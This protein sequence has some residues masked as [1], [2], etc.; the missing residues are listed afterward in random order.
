[1][2]TP[3]KLIQFAR[4]RFNRDAAPYWYFTKAKAL[5][6]SSIPEI[7]KYHQELKSIVIDKGRSWDGDAQEE[8]AQ[9]VA[10]RPATSAWARELKV[11]F[12]VLG[13][14]WVEDNRQVMFTDMGRRLL[15]TDD[16][17]RLLSHQIRKFQISNPSLSGSTG[18]RLLPHYA[19]L[20]TLI[21]LRDSHITK[22]EFILFV[23]HLTDTDNDLE[24]ICELIE[25][26]RKLSSADQT[27]FLESLSVNKRKILGRIWSYMANFLSFP[28]YLTYL[29]ARISIANIEEARS[30]LKWYEAGHAEYIEFATNKD[31][32]SYYGGESM[33]LTTL[34]AIH[35]YRSRGDVD[36]AVRTFKRAVAAGQVS[37]GESEQDFRCRIQGE[38]MLENW[39]VKHLNRLK[40]GLTFQ[41]SQYETE[42]AGRLDTLASDTGGRH[43]VIELKRGL[44]PDAALGQL[45]RYMGWVRMH[46]AGEGEEVRGYIIGDEISDYMVYA[47]LANDALNRICTLKT[48]A[49]LDVRLVL[50]K[51]A[52]DCSAEVVD[53]K[54]AAT[55]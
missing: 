20:K 39:L 55:P 11:L 22:T 31:W 12:G 1:M 23:S 29:K 6:P 25:T 24:R 33:Q 21:N 44:A 35:Y 51:S 2:S 16:A 37:P 30:V 9:A 10:G 3:R 15:T 46:L 14:V 40:S 42:T 17:Y 7:V 27:V 28:P 54:I 48:Y 5:K 41:S 32:F 26:F 45:F 43:V 4:S 34:D 13:T 19:L 49:D 52:K 50:H 18:V 36:H 38:A 47:T 53:L 8:F